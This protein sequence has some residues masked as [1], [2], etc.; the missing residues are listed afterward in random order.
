MHRTALLLALLAAPASAEAPF[1]GQADLTVAAPHHEDVV[2][3][4]VWYPAIEGALRDTYDDH[5][6][7][8][9]VRTVPN[10]APQEGSHPVV[11]L[12]HGMGG[13]YRS[14][15]WLGAGLAERGAVVVAVD[16]PN[17]SWTNFDEETWLAHWTRA[18]DLSAALDVLQADPR[19][20]A[21]LD[22]A[23]V[24]AAGFSYGGWT[25]LSLGGLKGNLAG[26]RAACAAGIAHCDVLRRGGGLEGFDVGD[27]D[28]SRADP[29]VTH[30]AAIDPGLIWG[31]TP[32]D[33]GELVPSVRLIGLGDADT[34]LGATDLDASG[35][36][37]LLPKAAHVQIVPAVHFTAMPL[38][39]EAGPAILA[40]EGD[41]PV[42]TDPVGTDRAAVHRAI[43]DQIARDLGL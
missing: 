36:A 19:F 1:V 3:G 10:A 43:V 40:A 29:R 14:L 21:H 26:Y 37:S 32:D 23:R 30:V 17:S 42:C 41:D 27:W 39:T 33:T 6:V 28:A 38:C 25:A 2:P 12:S 13:S 22:E 34:R 31:L 8:R 4:V 7:F 9:P 35:L 20:A 5:P 15:A 18:Q 11:A 16:H 24:M